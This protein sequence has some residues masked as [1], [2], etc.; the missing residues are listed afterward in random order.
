M[1]AQ[2]S[3]TYELI[4]DLPSGGRCRMLIAVLEPPAE[5][6]QDGQSKMR[7]DDVPESVE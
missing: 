5:D 1:E 4:V 2:G 7:R 6:P 3:Y